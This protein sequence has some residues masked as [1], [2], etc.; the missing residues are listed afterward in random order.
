MYIWDLYC[1]VVNSN[2]VVCTCT[3][4]D[5]QNSRVFPF[6]ISIFNLSLNESTK[7]FPL[8]YFLHMYLKIFYNNCTYKLKFRINTKNVVACIEQIP[9]HEQD[10]RIFY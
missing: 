9:N 3:Y 8:L 7:T 2:S 10:V 5:S 4:F 6:V 1:A